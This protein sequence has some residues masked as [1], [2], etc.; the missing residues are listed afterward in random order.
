MER[1]IKTITEYTAI[2]MYVVGYAIVIPGV[3]VL[4][5]GSLFTLLAKKIEKYG[6][7]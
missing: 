6:Q 7:S 4:I 2:A 5:I 1:L 3:M